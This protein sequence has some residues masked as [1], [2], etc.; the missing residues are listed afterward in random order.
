ME[1]IIYVVTEE[2]HGKEALYVI[3]SHKVGVAKGEKQADYVIGIF[4]ADG[5]EAKM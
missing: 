5:I 2:A 4:V 3:L 1:C